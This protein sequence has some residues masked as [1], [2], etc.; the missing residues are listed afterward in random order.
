MK[1]PTTEDWVIARL[2]W[3]AYG[4]GENPKVW[5][6][7]DYMRSILYLVKRVGLKRVHKMLAVVREERETK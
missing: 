4:E 2:I 5:G 7:H 6:N 1:E 3:V